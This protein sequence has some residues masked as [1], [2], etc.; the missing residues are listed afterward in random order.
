MSVNLFLWRYNST[1]LGTLINYLC[2][3]LYAHIRL[4]TYSGT[5]SWRNSNGCIKWKEI[6]WG[7]DSAV[8]MSCY[9][10]S[11]K[12]LLVTEQRSVKILVD[13]HCRTTLKISYSSMYMWWT[14]ELLIDLLKIFF[15]SWIFLVSPLCL[16]SNNLLTFP[17][18][19]LRS[20]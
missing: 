11:L 3:Q 12:L 16:L 7:E 14:H 13:P 4:K 15:S 5:Y 17:Y 2:E 9:G 1:K 8:R 6:D 10:L 19:R 20:L 18:F